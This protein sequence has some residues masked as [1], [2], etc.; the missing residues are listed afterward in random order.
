[1][2]NQIDN[3]QHQLP[4][5]TTAFWSK[6]QDNTF[7][8]EGVPLEDYVGIPL[9]AYACEFVKSD[10]YKKEGREGFV[11]ISVTTPDQ[12]HLRL[13]TGAI[14]M[15]RFGQA[16]I[17]QFKDNPREII[18]FVALSHQTAQGETYYPVPLHVWLEQQED[19][20][21]SETIQGKTNGSKR[22]TRK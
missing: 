4:A 9:N 22:Q 8:F 3:T 11:I 13:Q 12:M 1:M 7:T 20:E 19:S 10:K 14:Q 5:N 6:W 18:P 16:L 15:V 2:L 21:Q 17:E